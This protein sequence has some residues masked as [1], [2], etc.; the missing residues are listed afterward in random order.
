M[1][2]TI[3]GNAS[4]QKLTLMDALGKMIYEEPVNSSQKSI[5]LNMQAY[6]NGIYFLT[7]Q[8]A[9]GSVIHKKIVKQ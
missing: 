3:S 4:L 9:D 8:S 7:I 2:I 1:N 6:S 5:A